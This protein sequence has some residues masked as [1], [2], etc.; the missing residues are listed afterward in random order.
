MNDKN[1]SVTACEEVFKLQT[2]MVVDGGG[3]GILA[4]DA[5]VAPRDNWIL[6]PHPGEAG[7]LL[8]SR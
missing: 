8:G 6:T 4:K 2:P 7:Q 5:N 3:L 1:F